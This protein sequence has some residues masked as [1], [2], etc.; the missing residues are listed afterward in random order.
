MSLTLFNGVAAFSVTQASTNK[1]F[2]NIVLGG[3]IVCHL[4]SV[5]YLGEIDI[6]SYLNL[7]K[8]IKT[9]W[10]LNRD[11]HDH[12]WVGGDLWLQQVVIKHPTYVDLLKDTMSKGQSK[13]ST[14]PHVVLDS[15]HP[16][17]TVAYFDSCQIIWLDIT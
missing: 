3:I 6:C 13:Q 4:S 1:W 17:I 11:W 8:V 7:R 15:L 5:H 9:K 10:H 12:K 2:T 14:F 16:L